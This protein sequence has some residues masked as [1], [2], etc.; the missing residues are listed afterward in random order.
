MSILAV[1]FQFNF[2]VLQKETARRSGQLTHKNYFPGKHFALV[3]KK[4]RERERGKIW[5]RKNSPVRKTD[6]SQKFRVQGNAC[7][8]NGKCE[9]VITLMTLKY[10]VAV[11]LLPSS[12][13][14]T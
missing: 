4:R 8:L 9:A 12:F 1:H 14:R 2:S 3:S 6:F 11:Y 5:E 13:L 10:D 7:T